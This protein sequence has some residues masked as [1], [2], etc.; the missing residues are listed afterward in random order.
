MYGQN[1]V[2][3]FG[4]CRYQGVHITPDDMILL[5]AWPNPKSQIITKKTSNSD[6]LLLLSTEGHIKKRPKYVISV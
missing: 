3:N 1:L 2:I 4:K 6:R 5:L